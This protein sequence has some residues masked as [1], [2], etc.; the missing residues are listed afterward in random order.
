MMRSRM[1][2]VLL[3]HHAARGKRTA[4]VLND[5]EQPHFLAWKELPSAETATLVNPAAPITIKV[6]MRAQLVGG[7]QVL[8]VVEADRGRRAS[9]SPRRGAAPGSDTFSGRSTPARSTGAIRLSTNTLAP[10]AVTP[11]RA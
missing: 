2:A 9:G 6:G 11:P 8:G 3:E 10:L 5:L 4:R 7:G 1:V